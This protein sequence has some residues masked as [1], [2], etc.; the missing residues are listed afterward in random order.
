MISTR[1][2]PAQTA[3]RQL[4]KLTAKSGETNGQW[5]ARAKGAYSSGNILLLGGSSLEH[6][7][8]RAAQAHL[9]T[10]LLPSFWS[11]AGIV[12]DDK[13]FVS[14][15]LAPP[16]ELSEVPSTNGVQLCPLSEYDDPRRFPNIAVLQFPC[17]QDPL[18]IFSESAQATRDTVELIRRQRGMVDLPA[19]ILAWLGYVWGV[20]QYSNPLLASQGLPSAAFVETVYGLAGTEL[21]PGLASA[22]S[23]PEA[24]WQAAKWWHEYYQ[25]TDA[26]ASKAP[27]GTFVTRQPAAAVVE[28]GSEQ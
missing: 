19:L 26:A 28:F 22:S 23:C 7:R 4:K 20:G 8:I 14:V 18:R 27:S 24:I 25:Q 11:L 10:D 5:L 9:R 12:L 2:S 17:E 3:N 1:Q 15:P 16:R 21:T 13:S 6:F